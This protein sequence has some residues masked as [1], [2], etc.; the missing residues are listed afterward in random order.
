MYVLVYGWWCPLDSISSN[1]RFLFGKSGPDSGLFH[2]LFPSPCRQRTRFYLPPEVPETGPRGQ[3]FC[4]QI[5]LDRSLINRLRL[6]CFPDQRVSVIF[7][8]VRSWRWSIPGLSI[9]QRG[10]VQ[11]P[12]FVRLKT[13]CRRVSHIHEDRPRHAGSHAAFGDVH[14]ARA[15]RHRPTR[16]PPPDEFWRLGG[17]LI[18]HPGSDSGRGL[19]RLRSASI[20]EM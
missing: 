18:Q 19:T 7:T 2:G 16:K 11:R 3:K 8:A 20:R 9:D 10:D 12:E 14:A 4:N 6:E 13:T 17:H 15:T 1:V 5:G